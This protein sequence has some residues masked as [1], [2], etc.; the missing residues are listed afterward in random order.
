MS[1]ATYEK[2]ITAL[3]VINSYNDFTSE[4]DKIWDRFRD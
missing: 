1:K 4:G 3:L 2:W